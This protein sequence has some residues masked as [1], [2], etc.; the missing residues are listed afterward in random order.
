VGYDCTILLRSRSNGFAV[1]DLDALLDKIA[2][3]AAESPHRWLSF[4][5]EAALAPRLV[6]GTDAHGLHVEFFSRFPFAIELSANSSDEL[7]HP[8]VLWLAEWLSS[9]TN[10]S[11]LFLLSGVERLG[12]EFSDGR[13]T[14][15]LMA[16]HE[17]LYLGRRWRWAGPNQ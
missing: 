11:T 9:I 2:P 14:K 1:S 16:N 15:N 5:V 17:D 10:G 7:I 13:C 6:D 12:A 3:V 8:V 4:R